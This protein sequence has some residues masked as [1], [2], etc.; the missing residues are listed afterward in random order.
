M[1]II[2]PS[3][4]AADFGNAGVLINNIVYGPLKEAEPSALLDAYINRIPNGSV[5]SKN[6]LTNAI[7]LLLDPNSSYITGQNIIVDGGVQ[8]W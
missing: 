3:L 2:A 6:D 4:L 1:A 5:M 8:I 7:D